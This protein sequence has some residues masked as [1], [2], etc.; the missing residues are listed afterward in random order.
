MNSLNVYNFD[1]FP[2]KYA[3]YQ[4][5]NRIN[6]T[7]RPQSDLKFGRLDP[8]NNGSFKS[9]KYAMGQAENYDHLNNP[10]DR[11]V[12]ANFIVLP[13]TKPYF[14]PREPNEEYGRPLSLSYFGYN[15]QK[16]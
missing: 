4:D 3:S 9:P 15:S 7:Y 13:Y 8:T 2:G 10:Y 5:R 6:T 12:N 11:L 16:K 14:T 1:Q